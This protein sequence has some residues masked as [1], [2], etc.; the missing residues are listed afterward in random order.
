MKMRY[1]A[2]FAISLPALA[3]MAWRDI[4]Q[5]RLQLTDRGK[6][7]LVYNYGPQLA[8]G[9]PEDRRRCCY[10]SPLYTPG[11]VVVTD[12]FPKDH[13]HHRGLFW[14]WPHVDTPSGKYDL[15]MLKGVEPRF[16][17]W[18]EQKP[19]LLRVENGWFA[20]DK[21]IVR[22]TVALH[23]DK[24]R[25]IHVEI[26]LEALGQPVT[27]TG[28]L[29]EGKGYGGLSV[30]FAPRQDTVIRTNNGVAAKDEDLVPHTWAELEGTYQGHRA[31]L[32]ITP[33]P[34][35]PGEP[36]PWCLRAYGFIGASY[37]A[38]TPRVIDPGRPLRLSYRVSVADIH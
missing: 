3:Q 16:V 8:P 27:L 6:P 34:A 2:L 37:P 15:W 20:G 17:K 12:D 18:L 21:Q 10:V 25:I 14:A 22:E 31:V 29:E 11:G 36:N 26:T 30:R 35:N 19:G 33:D 28:S 23:V 4:G 1:F 24:D 5:G 7:V 13:Y 32:R 9:A 38:R